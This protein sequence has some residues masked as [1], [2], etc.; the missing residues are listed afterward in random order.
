[1]MIVKLDVKEAVDMVVTCIALIVATK[2]VMTPAV[3]D[4]PGLV[5]KD[6]ER[7]AVVH[8]QVVVSDLAERA[9]L[10]VAWI[11]VPA[12]LNDII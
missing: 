5:L 8:V 7:P 3:V 12:V 4:V 2:I 10:E 6:V 11:H 1:M 9:V